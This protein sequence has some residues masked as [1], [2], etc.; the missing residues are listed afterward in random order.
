MFGERYFATRE[1]LSDVVSG[2]LELA[3][4]TNVD[5]T[6][7]LSRDVLDEGLATPFL[8]VVCGEVNAGKS[9]LLNALF[10]ENICK[11]NVLPE[12]D[13]VI[14]YKYGEERRDIQVTD[15]LL[16]R[17]TPVEFLKDFNLVDTPG[18][19]SVEKSHQGISER[20]MPVADLLL[21]VFPVSNPWGA[22]TW[23]FLCRQSND[24]LHKVVFLLQQCD[25]R[26]PEDIPVILNHLRDLALKRIGMIPPVFPVSAKLAYEG[27]RSMPFGD[28]KRRKS[29][30]IEIE[31]F[32]SKSICGSPARKNMLQRLRL[33]ASGVMQDVEEQIEIQTRVIE[34]DGRLLEDV[35]REIDNMRG[36]MVRKHA[37]S[38]GGIGEVFQLETREAAKLLGK[39]LG[40]VPSLKRIVNGEDTAIR[41]ESLIQERLQVAVE[42]A[43]R[44][45]CADMIRNC[46]AQWETVREKIRSTM[47]IEIE[48]VEK[49]EQRLIQSQVKFV[50]RMGRASS[51]SIGNLRIRGVLDLALRQRNA[52]LRLLMILSLLLLIAAGTCGIIGIPLVPLI[53]LML[54]LLCSGVLVLLTLQ[55]GREIVHDYRDR[56]INSGESFASALRGDYEEGLRLF[57]RDYANGLEMVRKHLVTQKTALQPR[58][59]RWNGLFLALK[60]IEQDIS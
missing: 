33:A 50:R 16:E 17:F 10:A 7:R 15:L 26:E 49:I 58:L 3:K 55:S 19:N 40:V 22:A 27:K 56:L 28:E 8:F 57:F 54:A 59:Q 38:L 29:G 9:T 60:A 43:A 48:S 11:V 25:Q 20:F 18:T 52:S 21:F 41:M 1:R 6:G 36:Q 13:R 47:R 46:C 35:E 2:I 45:D 34:S 23:D 32:I 51:Q 12:T 37:Q 44:H 53:L 14:W 42:D 5:T 4:E 24:V 31:D 30:I 39:R